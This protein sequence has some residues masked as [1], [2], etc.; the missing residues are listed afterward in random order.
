MF[1]HPNFVAA[2]EELKR[3]NTNLEAM[4]TEISKI[5]ELNGNL[6]TMMSRLR[7]VSDRFKGLGQLVLQMK[8]FNQLLTQTKR[9]AGTSGMIQS[10][11]S[12]IL[13]LAGIKR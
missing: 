12:G 5:D 4:R 8:I 7:D 13:K 3:L 2:L 1:D 10:I 6:R 9:M 11:I